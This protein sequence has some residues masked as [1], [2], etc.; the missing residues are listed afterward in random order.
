[1]WASP[2]RCS[3]RGGGDRGPQ[4]LCCLPGLQAGSEDWQAGH[5]QA[6]PVVPLLAL[7]SGCRRQSPPLGGAPLGAVEARSCL[8]VH[9]VEK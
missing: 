9:S 8:C 2:C 4:H 7:L 3:G 6:G 1:M 5:S